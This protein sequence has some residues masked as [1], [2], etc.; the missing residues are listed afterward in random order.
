MHCERGS[1][2]PPQPR[3]FPCMVPLLLRREQGAQANK[4]F[5]LRM[6]PNR[7]PLT[8]ADSNPVP[9][10]FSA[11][12]FRPPSVR[13]AFGKRAPP[14][15]FLR[16]I[17]RQ[18]FRCNNPSCAALF[19]A[20]AQGRRGFRA[21]MPPHLPRAAAKAGRALRQSVPPPQFFSIVSYQKSPEFH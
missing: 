10:P 3:L 21:S 16:R 7:R 19:G 20:A 18:P 13:S 14:I 5:R 15:R 9:P 4:G 6:R 11:P 17:R 1:A 8:K 12:Q 2:Q